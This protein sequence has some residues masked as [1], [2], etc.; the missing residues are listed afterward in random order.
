MSILWLFIL[1]HKP[2]EEQF[3]YIVHKTC[4]TCSH[5]INAFSLWKSLREIY[6]NLNLVSLVFISETEKQWLTVT[7]IH[8][9]NYWTISTSLL[10][11]LFSLTIPINKN[12][13]PDVIIILRE[14][15]FSSMKKVG[16]GPWLLYSAHI[17]TYAF[18]LNY[19]ISQQLCQ[20]RR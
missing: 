15:T 20:G 3:L 1:N 7:I 11:A 9:P 18:I 2:S 5:L 4:F 12:N 13:A 8:S 17:F 14:Q 6:P 16:G 19:L 10:L